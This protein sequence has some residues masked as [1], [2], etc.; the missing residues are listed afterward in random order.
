MPSPSER[1]AKPQGVL[2]ATFAADRIRKPH[3]RFRYETRALIAAQMFR[4]H[5]NGAKH[6]GVLELGAAEGATMAEI[7]REL[8]AA[9]SLGIEYAQDL[10]DAA[11]PLPANCRLIQ[12]DATRA[13]DYTEEASCDLVTALALVEHV[14]DPHGLARNAEK[15][16]RPGGVFVATCPA[17]VWD[18]LADRFGFQTGEH[19]LHQVNESLFDEIAEAAGLEKVLYQRFMLAPIGVLPY[20][21]IPVP[22]KFAL[23][24][25]E[26]VA[27]LRLFNFLFVNQVYVARKSVR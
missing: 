4:R 5:G 10:I 13:T 16:L 7:H 22:P 17:S 24:L 6:P 21:K 3:L 15:V 23:G 1:P 12:G 8:G 11:P 9:S 2:D 25:D 19:H 14:E 20:L 26:A 27:A 18:D